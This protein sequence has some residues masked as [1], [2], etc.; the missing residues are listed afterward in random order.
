MTE[1]SVTGEMSL[2]IDTED[3]RLDSFI[4]ILREFSLEIWKSHIQRL[5]AVFQQQNGFVTPKKQTPGG[6][7]ALEGFGGGSKAARAL[8]ATTGTTSYSNEDNLLSGPS[9]RSTTS[10][11]S[12]GSISGIDRT[13]KAHNGQ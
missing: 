10:S 6:I 1:T 4:L 8:S 3:K 12:H 9:S 11:A 13:L 5:V 2:T 7:P